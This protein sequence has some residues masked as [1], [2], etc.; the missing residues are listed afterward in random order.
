MNTI[1]LVSSILCAF[2][3]ICDMFVLVHPHLPLKKYPLFF[4]LF[5][6]LFFLQYASGISV[7]LLVALAVNSVLLMRFTGKYYTAFYIPLGYILN[8]ITVNLL[9]FSANLVREIS[10]QEFNADIRLMSL[11][12][13]FTIAVSVPVLYLVRRL[14]QRYLI[15]IFEKKDRKIFALVILTLFL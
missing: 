9:L 4:F 15:H 7:L 14:F 12:T 5:S 3:L 2:M 11:F 6:G 1:Y 10:I 13:L 8:S